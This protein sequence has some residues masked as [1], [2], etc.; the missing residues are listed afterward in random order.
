[1]EIYLIFIIIPNQNCPVGNT[2]HKVLDKRIY[3]IEQ[4]MEN[5]MSKITL[6]MSTN[7]L[8]KEIK[9]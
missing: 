2:I 3:T 9:K 1:M 5:E 4:V 6:D 8:E 7:D